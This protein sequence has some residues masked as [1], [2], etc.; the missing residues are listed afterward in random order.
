MKTK[1]IRYLL[2]G[3]VSCFMHN[4]INAQ[5]NLVQGSQ[6][7]S[8]KYGGG[9]Y[10]LGTYGQADYGWTYREKLLLRGSVSFEYAKVGSSRLQVGKL[11]LDNSFNVF[12]L[13][14]KFYGNVVVGVGIG[15]EASYSSRNPI[16]NSKFLYGGNIGFELDYFVL[17]K[18][19]IKAEF[20]QH[21]M[22][23]SF[24]SP[25]YWTSSIGLCYVLN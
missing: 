1:M 14:Q 25:W 18:L 12:G 20:L 16:R 4:G 5:S 21:Y 24:I 19:S 10:S 7:I 11:N 2:I 8:L 3:V 9:R 13:A 17:K 6:T 23:N 22:H 15:S